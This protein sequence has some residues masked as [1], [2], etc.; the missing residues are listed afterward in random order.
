MRYYWT[1]GGVLEDEGGNLVMLDDHL[2]ALAE[3]RR[4]ER[5]KQKVA[6]AEAR[7]LERR[8]IQRA[9]ETK[10]CPSGMTWPE[11]F[12]AIIRAREEGE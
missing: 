7:R 2:A 3:A 10:K 8:A 4:E 1:P 9:I 6:L 5:E 12:S 11:W